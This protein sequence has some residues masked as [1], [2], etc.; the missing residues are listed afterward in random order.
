V[1]QQRS[2]PFPYAT[3]RI[4]KGVGQSPDPTPSFELPGVRKVQQSNTASYALPGK[5]NRQLTKRD[6]GACD[7]GLLN[8]IETMANSHPYL[9]EIAWRNNLI[10]DNELRTS[11]TLTCFFLGGGITVLQPGFNLLF[12]EHAWRKRVPNAVFFHAIRMAWNNFK[13]TVIYDQGGN[14]SANNEQHNADAVWLERWIPHAHIKPDDRLR[15]T[16]LHAEVL[17]IRARAQ[18]LGKLLSIRPSLPLCTNGSRPGQTCSTT[19][20]SVVMRGLWALRWM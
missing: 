13:R 7:T 14:S 11:R 16:F 6:L 17:D 1:Q 15:M 10:L 19:I 12:D 20:G 18:Q 3:P 5:P 9:G 2:D 4:P 8:E